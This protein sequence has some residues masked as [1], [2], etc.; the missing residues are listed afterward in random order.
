MYHTAEGERANR[1]SE[2]DKNGEDSTNEYA[3]DEDVPMHP[4]GP[5][6]GGATGNIGNKDSKS[7]CYRRSYFYF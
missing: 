7:T 1:E 6:Q 3:E 2:S 5:D 4:N